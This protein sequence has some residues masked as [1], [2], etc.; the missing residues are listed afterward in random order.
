LTIAHPN[1]RVKA[2]E[3]E[4]GT[5]G[6]TI[7]DRLLSIAQRVA[8]RQ[9]GFFVVRDGHGMEATIAYMRDLRSA[10]AAETGR[11]YSE[12][13]ICG[14][15]NLTVDFFI[16]PE[17]TVV[18]I[19]LSL[20]NSNSEFERDILKVLMAQEAGAQV[21]RLV[22]VAK[23]GGEKRARQASS[24]AMVEWAARSHQLEIVV[25]DLADPSA[26][27]GTNP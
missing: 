17:H 18:E 10:L 6:M 11:D 1:D 20:R 2:D 24:H 5:R 21:R 26:W 15:N 12:R 7:T 8:N 23:P 27:P 3:R 14:E 22:F 4:K 16:E 19:A 13:R 9:P 25:R